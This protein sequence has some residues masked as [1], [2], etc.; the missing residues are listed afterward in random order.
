MLQELRNTHVKRFG[1]SGMIQLA[2]GILVLGMLITMALV[3]TSQTRTTLSNGGNETNASLNIGKLT[4]AYGTFGDW[5]SLII[6]AGI[7]AF[8][9]GILLVIYV[10]FQRAGAVLE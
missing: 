9:L 4:T 3:F 2:M 6:L 10:Q 7:M 8:V 5:Y 1:I